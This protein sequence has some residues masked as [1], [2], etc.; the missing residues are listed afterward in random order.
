MIVIVRS[1]VFIKTYFKIPNVSADPIVVFKVSLG[2]L[3]SEYLFSVSA[4]YDFKIYYRANRIA[5]Y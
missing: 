5:I 2:N 4:Y 1:V 3:Y